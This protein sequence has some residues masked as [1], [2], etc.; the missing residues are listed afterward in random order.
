[1][2]LFFCP[3][4]FLIILFSL[5]F[6]LFNALPR[7]VTSGGR[8]GYPGEISLSELRWQLCATQTSARQQQLWKASCLITKL[9]KISSLFI[10]VMIS[11]NPFPFLRAPPH[12]PAP[13]R[14]NQVGAQ[15]QPQQVALQGHLSEVS[16]RSYFC[17]NTHQYYLN[18]N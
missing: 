12:R 15:P 17:L 7:G 9:M 5:F 3:F 14:A 8:R 16:L 2:R 6:S 10:L 18:S 4:L 13:Q 1:M 11:Q